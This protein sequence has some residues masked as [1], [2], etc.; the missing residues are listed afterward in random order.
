MNWAAAFVASLI[1][2][3]AAMAQP[4]QPVSTPE[5]EG[6]RSAN[7]TTG[8]AFALVSTFSDCVAAST[9]NAYGRVH[10][11][12]QPPLGTN[13]ADARL[14]GNRRANFVRGLRRFLG[15]QNNESGALILEVYRRDASAAA[16][17]A[18]TS[19]GV[20]PAG[21]LIY[22]RA[23]AVYE[24]N[25]ARGLQITNLSGDLEGPIGPYILDA[26]RSDGIE[27][28]LIVRTSRKPVSELVD[29]L[30]RVNEAVGAI[31]GDQLLALGDVSL[32]RARDAEAR[33]S[34]LFT[35][36]TEFTRPGSLSFSGGTQVATARVAFAPFDPLQTAKVPDFQTAGFLRLKVELNPSLFGGAHGVEDGG[37][38]YRWG[39]AGGRS[40]IMTQ[41]FGGRLFSEIVSEGMGGGTTYQALQSTDP[42]AF[43]IACQAL[44]NFLV[45]PQ[46]PRLNGDDQVA[47]K[48]AFAFSGANI[49]DP[50]IRQTP[51]AQGFLQSE[52][53]VQRLGARGLDVPRPA[54]PV[55]PQRFQV[56]RA[57]VEETASAGAL[58]ARKGEDG[59]AAHLGRTDL[60][61][62]SD[63]HAFS[64]VPT[65]EAPTLVGR[66][67]WRTAE[68]LGDRFSGYVLRQDPQTPL[69]T[70]TGY[71]RLEFAD[72]SASRA[73]AAIAGARPVRFNG[74]VRNGLPQSG[75]LQF[76]DN[77]YFDGLLVDGQPFEGVYV[78]AP[79]VTAYGRFASYKL[80]G[81]GLETAPTGLRWGVW[82]NGALPVANPSS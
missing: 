1:L 32:A 78:R 40:A 38:T 31:T 11:S 20:P 61:L 16:S 7:P 64:G 80:D 82:I 14:T 25:E 35:R 52:A 26:P 74:Y 81:E 48:W 70:V 71:G 77:S 59:Y 21:T 47:A 8:S 36:G 42:G 28:R 57:R 66:V 44:S 23:L 41:T 53:H 24:V 18:A 15:V 4:G 68:R 54:P 17:P 9:D 45:S 6:C 72:N 65:N 67:T 75:R 73:V 79:G 37:L 27:W 60:V 55:L 34:Q 49:A 76:E 10:L 50:S 13:P 29:N 12:W 51:C 46:A 19:T 62:E 3:S 33:I 5:A 43:Q 69:I 2:P 58:D 56:V 39:L 22:T 30:Q 63:T